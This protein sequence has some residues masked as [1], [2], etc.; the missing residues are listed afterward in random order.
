[1][2][3]TMEQWGSLS[4]TNR[5]RELLAN[6]IR[7]TPQFKADS[8]TILRDNPDI[9]KQF[10]L[11]LAGFT[12]QLREEDEPIV[13]DSAAKIL[14][15]IRKQAPS[16]VQPSSTPLPNVQAGTVPVV[17]MRVTNYK[18]AYAVWMQNCVIR[19]ERIA[20]LKEAYVQAK[21]A[22]LAANNEPAPPAPQREDFL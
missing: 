11:G 21:E 12:V 2:S 8:E 7:E 13:L 16:P 15:H 4:A 18:E 9:Q 10:F 14:A 22:Y 17:T 6:T 20:A 5:E 19:K 3:T 1:M